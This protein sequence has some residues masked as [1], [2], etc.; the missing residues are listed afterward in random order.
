M[1]LDPI[2]PYLFVIFID[3][4]SRLISHAV[5]MKDWKAIKVGS[6]GPVVLHLMF[7][8]DLLLFG[9]S[10]T[11]QMKCVILILEKFC[12]MFG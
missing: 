1:V 3:K 9:E 10:S 7:A 6:N 8:D 2:S 11:M 12:K 5:D 4:F